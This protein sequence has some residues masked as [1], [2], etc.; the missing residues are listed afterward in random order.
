MEIKKINKLNTKLLA[1]RKDKGYILIQSLILDKKNSDID[2]EKVHKILDGVFK[3]GIEIF[4]IL[5]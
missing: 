5:D 4:M 3:L 1:F 2:K